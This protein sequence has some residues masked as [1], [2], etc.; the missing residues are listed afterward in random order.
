MEGS[1]V[2]LTSAEVRDRVADGK[3]N[4]VDSRVS[5]SV[6]SI[7][8]K[9]LLTRFNAIM[10]AMLVI[11]LV[12]GHPADALFGFVMVANAV[13][14][15]VQELRAKRTLDKLSVLV[16]PTVT[17]LRDDDDKEIPTDQIVLDDVIRL[18]TGDQVPADGLVLIAGSV[19]VD[20]SLLTGEADPVHKEAGDSIMSGSFIVAGSTT[21]KITAVGDDAYAQHL[22]SEAKEFT[23]AKSELMAGI[24]QILRI[25]TWLLIPIGGLL[26]WSQLRVDGSLGQAMVSTVAG[27]VGMVPQGLVLLVSMA[28]AVAVI[29]LGKRRALVQ[30]L[31][32]VETLAR[33]DIVCVDKTGT[34][35]TGLIRHRET[36]ALGDHDPEQFAEALAALAAADPHPNPTMSGIAEAYPSDPDW[37]VYRFVPFSS[38]KKFSAVR[39]TNGRTWVV[40]APEIILGDGAS[41][42]LERLNETAASGDR[43]LLVAVTDAPLPGDDGILPE[44]LEPFGYLTFAEEIR[45]D[46]A[47][48]VGYFVGQHVTPKVISG[49]SASTVGAI[50]ATVG[51]PNADRTV[52]ARTL[53]NP[54]TAEFGIA[55]NEDAV[56]GRV[57]P[58]QKRSMVT[59]L[60]EAGHTVAM[61]GDGVNDVL[62]LKRA[63]IG[64][65]MG[66]GAPATKSVAQIVLLDNEFSALPFVVAEGRRVIAN[67]ERV[68]SLFVT[69]T[70]YA[71]I[72]AVA[73]GFVGW[74]FPLLPRHLT[75]IGSLTIGIPAFFLSF[76]STEEPVR[77]GAFRRIMR[78]AIP[79]GVVAATAAY[80]VYSAAGAI[81]ADL[82]VAR[83]AT[84]ITMVLVGMWVLVE[85]ISPLTPKRAALIGS[86]VG[87][88]ILILALPLSRTFFDLVIPPLNVSAVVIAVSVVAAVILHSMLAFV[89][90][91]EGG[92]VPWLRVDEEAT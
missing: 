75:L 62:A 65:A 58:D 66:A 59:A 34:L 83:S 2:G 74:V 27:V 40:G 79:A 29:R 72:L 10:S 67:M 49:D 31:P 86:L 48:T 63:D 85:L 37:T 73:I 81:N 44:E 70:V 90:H 92:W 13:I 11:V 89:D 20:E 50:A 43:V 56:F 38:A 64:I 88:F 3:V 28:M 39:F 45:G 30:E 60:Q 19:Q 78:F 82:S 87:A 71:A 35:T 16:E 51:I 1:V 41:E 54:E 32:A 91:H 42:L 52:D 61:T 23:L 7:L 57:T 15:I 12:F 33:V 47:D 9:N 22:A 53:P 4:I 80:G 55:I 21:V 18:V 17:V 36:V 68:A 84:T 24:D 25:V 69:K 26:L 14:G 5:R 8:R 77:P 6:S 46:A 76:E